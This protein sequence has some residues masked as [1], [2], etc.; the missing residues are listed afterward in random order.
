MKQILLLLG[1]AASCASAAPQ[2]A[3]SKAARAYSTCPGQDVLKTV[4]EVS[5][6]PVET[7]I[8]KHRE[9]R[10]AWN[11]PLPDGP[12]RILLYAS[13][14]DLGTTRI[15]LVAVRDSAGLWHVNQVA[16]SV[17]W[18][19]SAKPQQLTPKDKDLSAA[20]SLAVD[21]L[22]D[23][24]CFYAEPTFVGNHAIIGALFTTVEVQTPKHRWR[25]SW[26]STPTAQESALLDL[27]GK[28]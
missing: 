9:L 15:S 16:D 26:Y 17:I 10:S 20:E 19:A 7:Q 13:G 5:W 8:K 21:K 2:G 1:L 23:D 12:A 24:R 14:G 11:A 28:D 25:G 3:E 18:I 4:P 22:L 27:V 6:G